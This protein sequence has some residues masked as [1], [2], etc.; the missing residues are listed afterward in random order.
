[1]GSLLEPKFLLLNSMCLGKLKRTTEMIEGLKVIVAK[2]PNTPEKIAAQ[3]LLDL[4]DAPAEVVS[5]ETSVGTGNFTYNAN[6]PHKFVILLP[7]QGVDINKL[8]N[9]IADFNVQFFKLERLQ[10]QNIFFDEQTQMV[11]V[12]GLKNGAKAKVYFNGILANKDIMGY[13]PSGVT[14]KFIITD[15]NYRD[16]YKEKNLQ[17][18]LNFQ[19][20]NYQIE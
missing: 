8:R 11:I 13:L 9:A 12:N 15:Q 16:L 6:A 5:G 18:Y 1:M 20:A 17:Q 4:T 2:H 7:N 14:Q 3:Q 19:K 10:V